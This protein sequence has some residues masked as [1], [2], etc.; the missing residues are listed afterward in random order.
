VPPAPR[1]ARARPRA[2]AAPQ[3]PTTNAAIA[4]R[5]GKRVAV[6]PVRVPGNRE[7][8]VAAGPA[9]QDS[10]R[11]SLLALGYT[12][13]TDSE[14]LQL[15]S[16]TSSTAQRRIA[17]T[18]KV[19]AIVTTELTTRGDEV[20]AQSVVHDMWRNQQLPQRQLADLD[21]P[22]DVLTITRDVGRALD[23]V[24][25]RSRT[26]PH[27]VLFYDVENLTG[28]DSLMP[29]VVTLN[30][31]IRAAIGR[32]NASA[33][34]LDSAMRATRDATLRQQ[35]AIRRNA[36]LI[37]T[38]SLQRTR[39]DSIIARMSMRDMSD[40]RLLAPIELRFPASALQTAIAQLAELFAARMSQVNWGPRVSQ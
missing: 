19:G 15:V 4:A 34:P 40:D 14:L 33:L 18:L 28:V 16:Q 6:F 24:S 22:L 12:L 35:F 27:V 39:G 10:I 30:D 38:G 26:D 29:H 13:A 5:A 37:V 31:S 36:G 20:I 1:S 25:W 9:I 23:R 21:K 2:A 7:N 8:L 17:E 32:N 3:A 11:K